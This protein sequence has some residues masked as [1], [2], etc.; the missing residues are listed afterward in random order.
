MCLKP[1][2]KIKILNRMENTKLEKL[3]RLENTAFITAFSCFFG[4]LLIFKNNFSAQI[5]ILTFFLGLAVSFNLY[6]FSEYRKIG[7]SRAFLSRK[8]WIF[9]VTLALMVY[10]TLS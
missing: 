2:E 9:L 10:I 8:L 1:R 5:P 7:E 3:A 6:L 4:L